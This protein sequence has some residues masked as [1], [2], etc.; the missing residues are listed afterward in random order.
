MAK[1]L[2][3]EFKTGDGDIESYLDRLDQYFIAMDIADTEQNGVKRKAILL[4]SVGTEAYKTVRDLSYPAKPQ[5]KSYNDIAGILRKHYRPH[6]LVGTERFRFR[7]AKQDSGQS[8]NDFAINL[9]K[10][11]STCEFTGDQLEQ[12]LK[13]QFVHGLQSGSVK[14]KLIARDC[15]FNEAVEAALAEEIAVKDVREI[16]GKNQTAAGFVNKI[17]MRSGSKGYQRRDGNKKKPGRETHDNRRKC[18]RCGLTNHTK[19]QCKYKSYTCYKCNRVG[20]L[21][22][23]CREKRSNQNNDGK[24]QSCRYVASEEQNSDDDFYDSVFKIT[25]TA[26]GNDDYDIFDDDDDTDDAEDDFH[27]AAFMV[28][29]DKTQRDDSVKYTTAGPVF[30]PVQINGVKLRMELDTGAGPSMINIKDYNKYFSNV[31]L[32]TVSRSLH[33]YAGTPLNLAGEMQIDVTYNDQH[34]NA[35][36]LT[37]VDADNYAPPLFGR[38]WLRD[39]VLDW[40]NL[41][42]GQGQYSVRSTTTVDELKMKYS[43]I[44]QPG[45]GTVEGKKATL[46]LKDNAV[47]I[48]H[49]ARPVPYALRPAA[50]EELQ[51]MQDEG[52]IVPVDFSEWATPLVCIPKGDGKVRLCGDYKVTVNQAIHTDEYPMA[53]PEEVF[54]KMAGGDKFTKIDLKC[55]YQQMLLDEKSQELVTI[56]TLRGLFRYTRLPFGVSSSPAIWQRFMEQV[57]SGL[58]F[59]CAIMDDILVSGKNDEEH[60]QNLEKV[61]QRL[62]KYGLRV[63]P[64][65]CRF[66]QER[67]EYMGRRISAK[68]IQSTDSKIKAIK[69]APQ[70]RNITELRSFLGMVNFQAIFV[71]HLST[72]IRPLNDLLCDKPWSWTDDHTTVFNTIKEI[73]TS[74]DVLTH[75][76]PKRTLELAADASPYGLGAAILHVFEDGS[77]KPIA[78]AS[79]SLEKHEKGYAQLDKE[80]LAIMFGL[81]KFWM[82]LYGRKF[83]ILTDHKPL[84]RILGPKTGVPTM[85]A[86]RLQRWALALSAFMYDIKYIPGKDNTLA[87]ALSRLPLPTT[88]KEKEEVF[89]IE[90]KILENM[91]ITSKSIR[92][93]T[94]KDPVL[95]R[96]LE[97]TRTGWP[98]EVDDLRFKPYFNRKHEISIEQDCVMWGLRVIIPG[99]F[100]QDILQ[101]LHVAHPGMV[102]MKEIARSYVW[103]PNMDHEIEQTVKQCTS[104]QQTKSKPAVAPLMPWMWPGSPWQRVHIDFAEKDGKNY[105]VIIDA[106][107]K[108]PEII[109]MNNDTTARAT[110]KVLKDLFSKYGLPL[111]IVSDN[112][113]QFRSEEFQNFLKRNGVKSVRVSPYQPSSNGAAERMVQSFKKSLSSSKDGGDVQQRLY[114]FLLSYRSTKHATTGCSPASLFLGRELRTRLALVRPNLQDAVINK[115]SDQKSYYDV[116][117]KYRE[118][119]PGDTVVV[120]DPRKKETW[121]PGTIAE[122]SAPKSYIIILTDGRV[123]KRHVDQIKRSEGRTPPEQGRDKEITRDLPRPVEVEQQI[124]RDLP[125]PV[126]V[127]RQVTERQQP[128]TPECPRTVTP[129]PAP[130]PQQKRSPR[131]RRPPRRLIEEL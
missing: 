38:D 106:H 98:A 24:S 53:T 10:L 63:K 4:T 22:S 105:L 3:E 16:S 30:V 121:W 123:W 76:D 44:F 48:Y 87:D 119:F 57:L 120:M 77:K 101:E 99:K 52:I 37:V 125:R 70:P 59:T 91:P 83:T 82:Y 79:R 56:A 25:P 2:F 68:G 93:A 1:R 14:E 12:N 109:L 58:D 129:A 6:R 46:H 95:S 41:F 117:T 110:I 103:W 40:Q 49:K 50:D 100:Q 36:T 88:G 130:A 7:G 80:A 102:R 131:N 15:T 94:Q 118:F 108:W 65:K 54:S 107:S 21:K 78:Y 96:V 128:K 114:A 64:E 27:D 45:L 51:R 34:A 67:V 127:E 19:D 32:K 72:I 92:Q 62:Q 26:Y 126:E 112:G 73:L 69:D 35:L 115:Q 75:Y 86:Q 39:I 55:A 18:E 122:R 33:A 71:P 74:D 97:F 113:P 81:K 8:I 116:H 104:C 84:E 13:D 11:V 111:Q 5:D 47:P 42:P 90:D 61:F 28:D 23:E 29:D 66:M 31:P 60:L 124:T 17:H 43:V 20:H 89:R 9:K 85:A